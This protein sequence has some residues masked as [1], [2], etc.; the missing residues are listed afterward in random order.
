MIYLY[1]LIY[2]KYFIINDHISSL[3]RLYP[4]SLDFS[5]C[6]LIC[7]FWI[8][9]YFLDEELH[10]LHLLRIHQVVQDCGCRVDLACYL[11]D[12]LVEYLVN[13]DDFL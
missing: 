9:I 3:N 13:L 6:V 10:Q 12:K 4:S 2:L 11:T 8:F 5:F 7:V 1:L